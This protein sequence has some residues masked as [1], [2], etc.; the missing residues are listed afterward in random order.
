MGWNE[1][2]PVT[3]S[4]QQ[5][6]GPPT[7]PEEFRHFFEELKTMTEGLSSQGY[8]RLINRNTGLTLTPGEENPVYEMLAKLNE[9]SNGDYWNPGDIYPTLIQLNMT[10]YM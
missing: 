2:D 5:T 10:D 1:A 4:P 3:Y 6:R 7:E 8:D 9:I